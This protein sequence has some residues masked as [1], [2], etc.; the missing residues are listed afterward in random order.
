MPL[1]IGPAARVS[2]NGTVVSWTSIADATEYE[3][4]VDR[5]D[6]AGRTLQS[7]VVHRDGL[8]GQSVTLKLASGRYR[9]WIRA[10]RSEAGMRYLSRWSVPA[11]L[12]TESV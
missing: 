9:V 10:I 8:Y 1:V 6:D 7:R 4:W 2:T 5:V 3:L 11:T 12:F